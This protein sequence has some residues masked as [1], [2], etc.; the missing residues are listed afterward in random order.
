MSYNYLIKDEKV[1]LFRSYF[2][3]LSTNQGFYFNFNILKNRR[4][5]LAMLKNTFLSGLKYI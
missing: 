5:F 1:G 4:I 3:V 2:R